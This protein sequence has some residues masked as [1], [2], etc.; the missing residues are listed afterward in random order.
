MPSGCCTR[1]LCF[2]PI[3]VTTETTTSAATL[4][5]VVNNG[6]ADVL[7][8][9]T[10]NNPGGQ[11]TIENSGKGG[12]ILSDGSQLLRAQSVA[13]ESVRGNVGTTQRLDLE[14]NAVSLARRGRV[15]AS[16]A[17]DVNVGVRSINNFDNIQCRPTWSAS[18]QAMEPMMILLLTLLDRPARRLHSPL[19]IS[20]Q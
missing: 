9:G 15:T 7:L 10:I 16:A 18:Q 5:K 13:L 20:P 17:D 2:E 8:T 19:G 6:A 3:H 1:N 14:L 4:I 11:V 12:D